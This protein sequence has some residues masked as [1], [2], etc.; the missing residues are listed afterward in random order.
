MSFEAQKRGETFTVNE[1][2]GPLPAFQVTITAPQPLVQVCLEGQ[3]AMYLFTAGK[4]DAILRSLIASLKELA[5]E[6]R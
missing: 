6:D 3:R 1:F 4:D 5:L 2:V